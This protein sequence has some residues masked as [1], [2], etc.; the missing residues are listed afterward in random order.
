M[1]WPRFR[2]RTLLI[3]VAV[4]ALLTEGGFWIARVK[5]HADLRWETASLY[6]AMAGNYRRDERLFLRSAVAYAE[7]A[8]RYARMSEEARDG[9]RASRWREQSASLR[10]SMSRSRADAALCSRRAG[11]YEQLARK[12]RRLAAR[13]WL[14]LE[15]DPPEPK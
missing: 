10:K 3:V 9:D 1:R 14:P 8:E 2:L 13:P 5:G 12:Y 15:P 11:H 7:G 6:D 4:A